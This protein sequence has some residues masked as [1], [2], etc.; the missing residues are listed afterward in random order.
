MTDSNLGMTAEE[1]AIDNGTMTHEISGL[2]EGEFNGGYVTVAVSDK[3]SKDKTNCRDGTGMVAISYEKEGKTQ[4]EVIDFV[5]QDGTACATTFTV[6]NKT[7]QMGGFEDVSYS[8]GKYY[9]AQEGG[10]TYDPTKGK[11]V[12]QNPVILEAEL[13]TRLDGTHAMQLT[14]KSIV[15]PSD[16][17]NGAYTANGTNGIEG[18]AFDKSGNVYVGFQDTGNIYKGTPQS[19]GTYSWGKEPVLKTGHTDLAGMAFD[20]KGNLLVSFGNFSDGGGPSDP[21]NEKTRMYVPDASGNWMNDKGE[22]F[23]NDAYSI[24]TNASGPTLQDAEAIMVDHLGNIIIGSDNGGT[25]GTQLKN[26]TQDQTT[27]TTTQTT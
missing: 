23:K 18:Q 17:L 13:V 14:G 25:V 27:I 16:T 3:N 26:L 21:S 22:P 24:Q 2:T 6:D 12:L 20:S 1:Q 15:V 9:F 11:K 19:D 5:N 8:N 7:R 10:M 4:Y